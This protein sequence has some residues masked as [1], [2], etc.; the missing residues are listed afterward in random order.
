VPEGSKEQVA[1][2]AVV[3]YRPLEQKC[4]A[5]HDDPHAGQFAPS[6]L[7]PAACER[8]HDTADFKV[9]TFEH[10]PPFTS[11]LL[12]GQHAQV[13][14]EGCHPRVRLTPKLEVVRY[15]PLPT[16]CE[17]CHTDFHQGAFKGFEP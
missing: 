13:K 14:C 8:C 11:Y 4:S 1:G 12:E 17:E 10:R 3:R 2:R 7:E 16:A 15:K 9:T 5:C 6:R